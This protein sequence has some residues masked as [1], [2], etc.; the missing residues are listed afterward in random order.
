MGAGRSFRG[1]FSPVTD[2]SGLDRN[3]NSGSGRVR[4]IL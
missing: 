2:N 3:G 1:S 4:D